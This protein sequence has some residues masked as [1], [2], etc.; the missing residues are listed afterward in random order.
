MENSQERA[1]IGQGVLTLIAWGCMITYKY[2]MTKKE[3]GTMLTTIRNSTLTVTSDTHGAELHSLDAVNGIQY[4]WNGDP[5]YWHG[6][7]PILFPFVG[8]L[9]D[10][11]AS[12]AAGEIRLPRHG[13]AR[14][15][16]WM[17][18]SSDDQS[19]TYL[20]TDSEATRAGYPYAFEAR[21]TYTLGDHAVTTGLSVRNTGKDAMPFCIGGHTG[22]RVPLIEGEA[23]DDYLVEFEQPET[24]DCPQV[25]LAKG[26]IIDGVRNRLM[27]NSNSFRLNH[28][29]FRG[30]ALVFDRLK[31]RSVR[32]V[33]EKSGHGVRVDFAGMEY[34]AIWSP[35][36]D[37]PF[38]CIEPWTGTA[39]QES[40]DDVFEHKQGVRL[41]AEGEQADYA[42]TVTVF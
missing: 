8:A 40:E 28:I 19:V 13:F 12:S 5:A 25:D 9:R 2:E 34:L 18:E 10:D 42:F 29:L 4:L 26:L 38:V 27:T 41:L 14:T 24:L 15:S 21:V 33:S 35:F 32:L 7:A 6:R 3:V 37:C 1:E 16:D 30:D 31:S 20:L 17:V 22:F 36:K 23:F 39:T 11:H